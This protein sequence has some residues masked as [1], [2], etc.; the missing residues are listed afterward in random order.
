MRQLVQP[1]ERAPAE[2]VEQG[3]RSGAG[4]AFVMPVFGSNATMP[5]GFEFRTKTLRPSRD[6]RTA[7][8]AATPELWS[9]ST[10]AAAT[11]E[12]LEMEK[13]LLSPASVT[14]APSVWLIKATLDVRFA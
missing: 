9:L 11:L 1:K 10:N 7:T 12:I 8:G 2:R 3:E 13:T 4:K 5:A 14:R 6:A